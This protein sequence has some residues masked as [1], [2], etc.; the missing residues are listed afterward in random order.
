MAFCLDAAF[1]SSGGEKLLSTVVG[2]CSTPLEVKSA[3]R[4]KASYYLHMG[5]QPSKQKDL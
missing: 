2:I 3:P 1:T 4:Q 5:Q